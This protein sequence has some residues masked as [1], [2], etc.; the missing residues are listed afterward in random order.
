MFKLYRRKSTHHQQGGPHPM[1]PIKKGA[2][3]LVQHAFHIAIPF[4]PYHDPV[5]FSCLEEARPLFRTW[6]NKT[7]LVVTDPFLAKTFMIATLIDTLFIE[8]VSCVLYDKTQA[9]PKVDDVEAALELYHQYNCSAIIALGGGSSIDCAKAIGARAAFPNKP[10]S[11]LKGLLK[12]YKPIPPLVAIPTTAGTGSEVTLAAVITD[13]KTHHK[14][15]INSFTPIPKYAILD[16]EFTRTLPPSL[17]ATTGMDALCHAVEAY[18]GHSNTKK[19]RQYAKEAVRLIVQNIERVYEDGN[20]MEARSNMLHASFLAGKAFTRAYVGYIHAIAHALGGQYN[21][22]HGL[23]NAII[24]PYM[25]EAYGQAVHKPLHE[26]AICA[27]LST[28]L[29]SDAL[30]A[31]KFVQAIRSLNAMM[32][33]PCEIEQ[34]QETDIPTMAKHASKEANPLYPVPVLMDQGELEAMFYRLKNLEVRQKELIQ[35]YVF[36]TYR[37]HPSI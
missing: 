18:I 16:A 14:Y 30:G 21:I 9:N 4:L 2:C 23:A 13:E 19:T 8:N 20:D 25:L 29:E 37:S 35:K 24:M 15:T 26:L 28:P 3:R 6:E 34:I 11:K 31:E 27:G 1:N 32:N 12:V 10:L 5:C 33:I 22:P 17:S 36:S 7:V